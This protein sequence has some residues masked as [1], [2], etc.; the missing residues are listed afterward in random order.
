[1]EQRRFVG[2]LGIM[3][4]LVG[5]AVAIEVAITPAPAAEMAPKIT[6]KVTDTV[7]KSFDGLGLP[8]IV[9]IQY[10]RFV[11]APGFKIEGEVN[12]GEDHYELCTV[13]KGRINL[14]LLDGSKVSHSGGDIFVV[15][16]NAKAKLVTVDPTAGFRETYWSINLK[17]RK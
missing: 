10:R 9:Q 8:G 14:T 12:L 3:A 16:L 15:P 7:L 2:F 11:A 13:V 5:V 17:P 1:M 6:G 4:V